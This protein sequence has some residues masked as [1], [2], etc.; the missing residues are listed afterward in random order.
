M[1]PPPIE[2]PIVAAESA[3]RGEVPARARPAAAGRSSARVAAAGAPRTGTAAARKPA[4]SASTKPRTGAKSRA[5]APPRAQS[6]T[7]APHGVERAAARRC[8][9]RR[10]RPPP[11]PGRR[12]RSRTSRTRSKPKPSCCSSASSSSR[13]WSTACSR[14][15]RPANARS[16]PRRQRRDAP[17]T[18]PQSRPRRPRSEAEATRWL[19]GQ[20][21]RARRD[22]RLAAPD[23]RRP[24][25]EAQA[26]CGAQ[27]R[28]AGGQASDGRRVPNVEGRPVPMLRNPPA[29]VLRSRRREPLRRAGRG[30]AGAG[31]V[32]CSRR[33]NEDEHESRCPRHRQLR[34]ARRSDPSRSSSTST[35]TSARRGRIRRRSAGDGGHRREAPARRPLTRRARPFRAG[36]RGAPSRRPSGRASP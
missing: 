32:P 4:K 18:K 16:A 8:D 19:E 29:G 1:D 9:R 5:R 36:S 21:G 13:P 14:K 12:S 2:A 22:R 10:R 31:E 30:D 27:R 24:A 20:R 3:T 6:R 33:R 7:T 28:S 15:C 23:R 11:M 17:Q 34:Y 25:V 35:G 26:G